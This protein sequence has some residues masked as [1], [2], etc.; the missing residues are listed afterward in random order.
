MYTGRDRRLTCAAG[1]AV[2]D[3]PWKNSL[4]LWKTNLR[5]NCQT[6]AVIGFN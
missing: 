4:K 1:L 5:L 6:F 2:R 3:I